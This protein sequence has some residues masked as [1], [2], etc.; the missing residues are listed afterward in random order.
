MFNNVTI[1]NKNDGLYVF[2][3]LFFL[4]FFDILSYSWVY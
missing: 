1:M 3:K 4:T 2:L